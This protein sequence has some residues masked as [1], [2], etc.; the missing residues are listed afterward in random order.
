[1]FKKRDKSKEREPNILREVAER[2]SEL[3][4]QVNNLDITNENPMLS[5]DLVS[6]TPRYRSR[7][8]SPKSVH[9]AM[10]SRSVSRERQ[11]IN[12]DI[13]NIH[14]MLRNLK[15]DPNFQSTLTDGLGRILI[16]IQCQLNEIH[17]KI[18]LPCI[19][20]TDDICTDYTQYLRDFKSNIDRKLTNNY[21][22]VDYDLENKIELA[23]RK[24]NKEK[25][26]K[27]NHNSAETI[28]P[29]TSFSPVDVIKGNDHKISQ[30][31]YNFP[32]R[33]KFKGT[34]YEPVITQ[35]LDNLNDGQEIC[36]ISEKEFLNI[37][38]KCSTG[39]AYEEICAMI[40]SKLGINQIYQALLTKY[41]TRKR[42]ETAKQM[43]E[44]YAPPSNATLKSIQ[45]DIM[46][47]ALRSKLLYSK[48][49]QSMAYNHDTIR[50]LIK[51]L[52]DVNHADAYRVL[53]ELNAY[54]DGYPEYADFCTALSRYEVSINNNLKKLGNQK[55]S[56]TKQ[57]YNFNS[58][59]KSTQ[60][61]GYNKIKTINA[62][63]M[64]AHNEYN[65]SKQGQRERPPLVIYENQVDRYKNPRNNNYSSNNNYK[66]NGYNNYKNNNY[67]SNTNSNQTNGSNQRDRFMN[68]N[69]KDSYNKNFSNPNKMELGI[70]GRH[71]CTLC[72]SN[73]HQASSG[74]FRMRNDYGRLVFCPPSQDP[75][76]RCERETNKIL[77]HPEVLCFNRPK[78][79][80]MLSE[81]KFKFP[82]SEER[83]QLKNFIERGGRAK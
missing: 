38:R 75:C 81:G 19:K 23:V 26:N 71:S 31:Q 67:R 32:F 55:Y 57:P 76:S 16:E 41:D 5:E 18:G 66:Q 61:K 10:P 9:N 49:S 44:S 43:L 78:M 24:L 53:D 12:D 27:I 65:N 74:C 51:A 34:G 36:H 80:Q 47:L 14:E 72:G 82:T 70:R 13:S 73:T 39:A 33:A 15:K 40:E 22:N 68:R 37:M 6:D 45:G 25:L 30:V 3:T 50:A 8:Q 64:P 20:D 62:Q 28:F 59:K 54:Y 52:P 58:N 1:M 11:S 60:M 42:P 17:K 83:Q 2:V 79:K 4:S 63:P 48:A 21:E 56:F 46:A 7:S 35:W 29:P 77:Y 69:K